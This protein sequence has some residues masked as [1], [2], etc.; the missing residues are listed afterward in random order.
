MVCITKWGNSQ[1]IRIARKYLKE[2]GLDIGDAVNIKVENGKIV[3][4]PVMK[5]TRTPKLKIEEVFNTEVQDNQEFEWGQ[6]GKEV[7]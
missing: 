5:N 3:I 7:W 4:E 2:V 1:G 6:K